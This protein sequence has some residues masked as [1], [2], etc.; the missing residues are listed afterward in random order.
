VRG[1]DAHPGSKGACEKAHRLDFYQNGRI[2]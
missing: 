2:G 1:D